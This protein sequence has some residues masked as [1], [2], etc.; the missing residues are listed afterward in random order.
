M[1]SFSYCATSDQLCPDQAIAVLA[2]YYEVVR[3]MV[4]GGPSTTITES[5]S[6]SLPCR[7]R[8]SMAIVDG[9][10]VVTTILWGLSMTIIESQ[11]EAIAA[12]PGLSM[13]IFDG[14]IVVVVSL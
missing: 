10:I 14:Q 6:W 2:G 8:P 5:D 4:V 9:Q 12:P 1:T 11:L 7:A 13:A 3:F